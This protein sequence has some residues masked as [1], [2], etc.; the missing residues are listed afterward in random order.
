MCII[1][2][3]GGSK[4]IPRKNIREFVGYPL[5]AWTII[6]ALE[7]SIFTKVIVDTDDEEI[8]VIAKKFGAEV[9]YMRPSVLGGDSISTEAVI[10]NSIKTLKE[11]GYVAD[12][13][14]L[15]QAT[16]PIRSSATI[17]GAYNKFLLSGADSL[18]VVTEGGFFLWRDSIAPKPMFDL[19]KRPRRQDMASSDLVF[20]EHGSMYIF[21][22]EGFQS[23]ECRLFGNLQIYVAD[24]WEA[25]DIDSEDDWLFAEIVFNTLLSGG[26]FPDYDFRNLLSSYK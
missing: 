18:C 26:K 5:V 23:A 3:R 14:V 16:S 4:G 21:D 20:E 11:L 13:I 15:L 2:A 1:P 8:A 12:T 17:V 24:R 9:P 10:L 7:S 6:Q 19:A 22:R 25:V